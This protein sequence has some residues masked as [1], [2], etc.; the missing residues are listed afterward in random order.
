MESGE[1]R[2]KELNAPR[3]SFADVDALAGVS[4]GTARRWLKGYKYSYYPPQFF[5]DP[6]IY[7]PHVLSE[8]VR[9]QPPVG[10]AALKFNAASF[11]DLVEVLV[12]SGLRSKGFSTRTVRQINEYCQLA[13]WKP[14]P[15][16]TETFKVQG[17]DVFVQM[18]ESPH[19]LN[20]SKQ[21]GMQAWEDALDPFLESVDFEQELAHRWWPL[22]RNY[23]I[24]I[25]PD[26]GYGFPTVLK[27]GVR[28]EIVAERARM[29][30][31]VEEIA[32][33]FDLTETEVKAALEYE[34]TPLAA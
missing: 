15:L 30:E 11:M 8:E 31:S 17:K 7:L 13:L 34:K 1:A 25:D 18:S 6:Y 24:V 22:G 12:I 32:Y 29:E 2:V 16:V 9:R 5:G 21:Q 10:G 33:D 23:P 27:T 20:V 26:Y 19:L 3:Y 4:K 14:R 28:T